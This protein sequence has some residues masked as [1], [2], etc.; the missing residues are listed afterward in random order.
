MSFSNSFRSVY[1]YTSNDVKINKV[2]EF[3][4]LGVLVCDTFNWNNHINLCISKA[5][6][7]LGLLKRCTVYNCSA[8]I[9]LLGF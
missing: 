2:W 9:K 7:R 1:G 5:N 4:D 8:I 6:R 3:C